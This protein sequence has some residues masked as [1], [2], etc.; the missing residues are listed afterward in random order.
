M[1]CVAFERTVCQPAAGIS[2]ISAL[3]WYP[4]VP[5]FSAYMTALQPAIP[6]L[7]LPLLLLDFIDEHFLSEDCEVTRRLM[8]TVDGPLYAIARSTLCV[9]LT[10]PLHN[11]VRWVVIEAPERDP[12]QVALEVCTHGSLLYQYWWEAFLTDMWYYFLV[13]ST[14]ELPAKFNK[15]RQAVRSGSLFVR[16]I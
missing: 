1:H 3:V 15:W 6:T 7:C 11:V 8:K 4:S 16:H 12:W 2:L 5:V 14:L 9:L 13:Q 10:Q